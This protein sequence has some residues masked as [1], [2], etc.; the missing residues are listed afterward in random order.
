MNLQELSS[1]EFSDLREFLKGRK[2]PEP[3]TTSWTWDDTLELESSSSSEE[4]VSLEFDS[5]SDK[6]EFS[7]NIKVN[8]HLESDLESDSDSESI[9]S[10]ELDEAIFIP[11]F[12]EDTQIN[13]KVIIEDKP[14]PVA[15]ALFILAN[16]SHN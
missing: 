12:E 6:S 10:E 4:A 1:E 9:T 2:E 11:L 3:E 16:D 8:F 15:A 7:T 13:L 14:H 5:D